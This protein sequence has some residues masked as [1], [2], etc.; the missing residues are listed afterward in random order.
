MKLI[1]TEEQYKLLLKESEDTY[2]LYHGTS[3]GKLDGIKSKPKKLFL[4]TDKEVATYYA[5]KGGEDYFMNKEM[6][7]ENQYGETPDEYL[8]T[9]ENGELI[10][11][12]EL[13]PKD[14][15]PIVIIF[16]ILKDL[17]TNIENFYG[18]KGGELK[19]E[20]KYISDVILYEW[21]DLDY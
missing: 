14:Q 19:I 15:Q 12:K 13:Y 16:E 2:T 3:S 21:D 17:I 20:P 6:E 11:F 9:E 4:T 10:M 8:N 7:F 18:Y 5:A 1:L